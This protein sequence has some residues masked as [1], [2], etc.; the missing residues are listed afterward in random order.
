MKEKWLKVLHFL[1]LDVLLL[2]VL[3]RLSAGLIKKRRECKSPCRSL[4]C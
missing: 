2:R 4:T 3:K 1:R